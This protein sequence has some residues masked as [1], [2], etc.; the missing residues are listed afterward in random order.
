MRLISCLV[1]ALLVNMSLLMTSHAQATTTLHRGNGAEPGTLDPHRSIASYEMAII[2][3]LFLG[4]YTEDASGKL[5]PGAAESSS[6][7]ADGLTYT[8]KLREGHNW[9]DGMPVTA[10]DFVFS[11]RRVL[12]PATAAQYA[13]LLYPIQNAELVNTGKLD[14]EGLGIRAI[15]P[16]TLEIRL[17]SPTPYFLELLAHPASFAIPR[18][19]HE[20]YG[21]DWVKSSNIAS[22]GPFL[23]AAWNSHEFVLLQ[24]NPTFYEADKVAIEK[25]Y[26]Y[27]T[28][29]NAAALK[30]F[31][32]GELDLNA[33]STCYPAT[34][35]KWLDENMPGVRRPEASLGTAYISFNT[36][37]VPFNDARVRRA[38]SLAL[39][40]KV[41][42]DKVL[43][44]GEIPAWSFVP[45][46]MSNYHNAPKM[47][48]A[49]FD[50]AERIAKAKTLLAEAGYTQS[51]PLSF[52]F[53]YRSSG[54][55]K[56]QAI[57]MAAMWKSIGVEARLLAA[58]PNVH[59]S[60]LRSGDFEVADDGWFADY[61]DAQNF[62]FLMQTSSGDLNTTKYSNPEF[63]RLMEEA[64]LTLDLIMRSDILG[65]AE[66]IILR[67]QPII[68]VYHS[69]NLNIVGR[70]IEGWVEN[71]YSVH[72]TRYIS[73]KP[74]A[75][76]E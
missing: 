50:T 5:I 62:L 45:P 48:S 9:S 64:A 57:V 75:E 69:V 37:K 72:L 8:F 25:V 66:A 41:I 61:G 23:L 51:N 63:D 53:R 40:R 21:D 35:S 1:F 38:L 28:D 3:D 74:H 68:P 27:P 42:T 52:N 4:L 13:S 60:T 65:R 16:K 30:R 55:I 19:V 20:I 34:Q 76:S 22:N 11:M 46:G 29:D 73:I 2:S 59:Y 71:S 47:A 70:H 49:S 56:K 7:S 54:S 36:S 58:E 33:C 24:K 18:H 14:I 26:Y 31:R 6:V 67:D 39:D 10:E 15:D 44:A 12:D 43:K 17:N 32:A